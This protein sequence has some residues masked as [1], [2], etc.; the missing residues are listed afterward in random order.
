MHSYA[1][2][3]VHNWGA[4]Q[5]HH[6][7]ISFS[8]DGNGWVTYH[9]VWLDGNEQGLNYS[10]FSGF[11]LGWTPGVVMNFQLNGNNGNTSWGNVY[12][13]DVTVYRW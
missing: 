8:Q 2:C 1:P 3:N 9:S 4:N 7:Q 6:V 5:W 13:D 10:V 12:L 11:R